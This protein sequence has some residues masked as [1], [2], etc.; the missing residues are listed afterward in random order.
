M[1]ISRVDCDERQTAHRGRPSP[2]AVR[3]NNTQI[4]NSIDPALGILYWIANEMGRVSLVMGNGF[5]CRTRSNYTYRNIDHVPCLSILFKWILM[6]FIAEYHFCVAS[7]SNWVTANS[8]VPRIYPPSAWTS[9]EHYYFPTDLKNAFFRD[10]R[11]RRKTLHYSE[12][13]R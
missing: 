4:N 12:D 10:K 2:V 7:C 13:L 3:S 11:R 5:R 1:R 8:G 9:L 6:F